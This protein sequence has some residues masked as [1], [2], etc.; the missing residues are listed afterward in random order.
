[1]DIYTKILAIILIIIIYRLPSEY[2]EKMILNI[3]FICLLGVMIL[4]ASA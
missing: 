4:I 3:R 1:M 2:A